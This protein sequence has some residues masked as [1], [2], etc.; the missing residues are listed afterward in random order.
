MKKERKRNIPSVVKFQKYFI[1]E[2]ELMIIRT[3]DEN[4]IFILKMQSELGMFFKGM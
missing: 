4:D 3:N 2:V 1:F